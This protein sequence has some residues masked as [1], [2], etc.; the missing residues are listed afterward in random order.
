M[1]AL[2]VGIDVAKATLAVAHWQNDAGRRL[3]EFPNALAGFERLASRLRQE[4]A[5]RGA[6]AIHVALEP[7]AGYELALRGI[8]GRLNQAR[9]AAET[10]PAGDKFAD[11]DLVGGIEHCRR[12][13]PGGE[14]P[15]GD[16]ERGKASE[17]R[18]LKA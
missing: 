7:T 14:R 4:Q 16:A 2:F 13:A 8:Q 15:T 6:A 9:Y 10:E 12:R 17:V 11:C 1:D 18:L 5:A 3:G